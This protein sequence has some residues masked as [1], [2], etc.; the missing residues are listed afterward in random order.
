MITPDRAKQTT[1]ESAHE[2]PATT[3]TTTTYLFFESVTQM[4][5]CVAS[6]VRECATASSV[7]EAL[8]LQDP[9]Q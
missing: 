3:T 9:R 6:S 2:R 8:T 1:T 7:E 4:N 5:A